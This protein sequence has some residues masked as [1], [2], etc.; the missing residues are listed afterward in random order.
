MLLLVV[1][2]AR[3][4][5]PEDISIRAM[6]DYGGVSTVTLNT[7]DFVAEGYRTMS[8]ELGVAIANKPF[9]PGETLGIDGFHVGIANTFAFIRTGSTDGT[10][11]SGWDLADPDEDPQGFLYIPQIQVR[12]GLPLSFELGAN[13]GWVGGSR[14]GALGGYVRW[15][16]V[17]GWRQAPDVAV[18]LGYAA[19]VGN[20][21][22][23]VGTFDMSATVGYSLPFGVTQGVNQAVFSPYVHVGVQQIH[24]AVRADL[25]GTEL[26]GRLA[27]YW[28]VQNPKAGEFDASFAP[29]TVGGGFRVLNGN[30]AATFSGTYSLGV[31]ATAN[32]GF[33]FVY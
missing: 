25:T 5:F 30:F 20:D 1:A 8:K 18:Q 4:E 11:P 24:S 17:E 21:E 3:A 19:Y 29:L 33:A 9:A 16:P 23:E 13:L 31:I 12:K 26:E 32:V 27:E 10:N 2:V 7:A 15:A 6:D 28:G 22:L 14:T